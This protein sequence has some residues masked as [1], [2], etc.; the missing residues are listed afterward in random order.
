MISVVLY[1]NNITKEIREV[2]DID[3]V[4][5]D[6][7]GRHF[8]VNLTCNLTES[9]YKTVPDKCSKI[10]KIM[11]AR[12]FWLPSTGLYFITIL[13]AD[14]QDSD[15]EEDS[16]DYDSDSSDGD[17]SDGGHRR[18]RRKVDYSDNNN[19]PAV[20]PQR[21]L[22]KIDDEDSGT[23][24]TMDVDESSDTSDFTSDDEEDLY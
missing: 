8:Y 5:D 1:R 2:E 21:L 6:V 16:S 12:S 15:S 7:C 18:K 3:N 23:D 4:P 9:Q 10:V 14:T 22:M 17:D 13:T 20:N 19:V 11:F 24:L